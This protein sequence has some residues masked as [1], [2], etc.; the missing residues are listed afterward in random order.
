MTDEYLKRYA[1]DP[2]IKTFEFKTQTT[3]WWEDA[4]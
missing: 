3:R 2:E 1:A 4:K